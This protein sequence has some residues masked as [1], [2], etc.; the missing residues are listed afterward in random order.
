LASRGVV[1]HNRVLA[2]VRVMH[3]NDGHRGCASAICHLVDDAVPG[4]RPHVCGD[5]VCHHRRVLRVEVV[6]R[7]RRLV[8]MAAP[9]AARNCYPSGIPRPGDRQF[10]GTCSPADRIR[11][12]TRFSTVSRRDVQRAGRIHVGDL[13]VGEKGGPAADE[14]AGRRGFGPALPRGEARRRFLV[15]GIEELDR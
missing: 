8:A 11:Y 3:A 2:R 12:G 7:Q 5:V 4:R 6:Y 1:V 9:N 15:A 10:A 14:R 13:A